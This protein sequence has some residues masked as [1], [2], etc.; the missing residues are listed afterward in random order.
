MPFS[1]VYTFSYTSGILLEKK[2][3]REKIEVERKEIESVS[4]KRKSSVPQEI[5]LE[6]KLIFQSVM[7]ADLK[8]YQE[9][10]AIGKNQQKEKHIPQD[11]IDY[12]QIPVEYS[13]NGEMY[14]EEDEII[15]NEFIK[16]SLEFIE[17]DKRLFVGD[18]SKINF[19]HF[20][21]DMFVRP[22]NLIKFFNQMYHKI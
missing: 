1:S 6:A 2:L 19:G 16:C 4:Q 22:Q 20:Q 5:L 11:Q 15:F 7:L 21:R 14:S 3:H 17:E 18:Y 10:Y 13:Y 9:L 12:R 8:K